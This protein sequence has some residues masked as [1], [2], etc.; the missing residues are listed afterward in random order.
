MRSAD[1][2]C[3]F[4]DKNAPDGRGRYHGGGP[5]LSGRVGGD[6][7]RFPGRSDCPRAIG[8]R[9][10]PAPYAVR[11]ASLS[12]LPASNASAAQFAGRRA[13]ECGRRTL[14]EGPGKSSTAECPAVLRPGQPAY[15]LGIE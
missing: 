6:E 15:A 12:E 7:G 2:C 1:D 3:C 9:G 14:A 4:T 8:T 5:A 13:P 11:D 10:R